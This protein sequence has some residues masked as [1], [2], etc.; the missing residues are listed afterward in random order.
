MYVSEACEGAAGTLR[1]VNTSRV[2]Y[3]PLE[4]AD[5]YLFR[6]RVTYGNGIQERD[7][8]NQTKQHASE[9]I[10]IASEHFKFALPKKKIK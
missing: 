10:E 3:Y 6:T 4:R 8:L 2:F 1:R 5:T 7:V 9:L